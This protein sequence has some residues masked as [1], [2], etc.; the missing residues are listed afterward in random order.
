MSTP[1]ERRAA[2]MARQKEAQALVNAQ[3]AGLEAIIREAIEKTGQAPH[4]IGKKAG[5]S[6]P[7]M[8]RF[9]RSER[10]LSIVSLDRLC[11]VLGLTLK[12]VV[13]S[14]TGTHD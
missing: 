11:Y 10:G 6:Q 9:M 3:A 8:S 2:R 4:A 14:K 13:Q 1:E 12:P 5:I 7:Q